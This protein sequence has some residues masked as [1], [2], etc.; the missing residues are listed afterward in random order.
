MSDKPNIIK[1]GDKQKHVTIPDGWELVPTGTRVKI[2]MSSRLGDVGI[3]EDL[4]AERGYNL[5]ID[6]DKLHEMFD[7]FSNEP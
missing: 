4:T 5:R 7:Q 6:R 1:V 2:V 3:T